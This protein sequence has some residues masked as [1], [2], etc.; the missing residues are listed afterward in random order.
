M[1]ERYQKP[2][3]KNNS[4]KFQGFSW[5]SLEKKSSSEG[6]E[7]HTYIERNSGVDWDGVTTRIWKSQRGGYLSRLMGR[8]VASV[9][10][11]LPPGNPMA[12]RVQAPSR[13]RPLSRR[14]LSLRLLPGID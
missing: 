13:S 4:E 8:V 2:H 5:F 10:N 14:P 3:A 1:K 6:S 11:S 12:L 7:N 9:V